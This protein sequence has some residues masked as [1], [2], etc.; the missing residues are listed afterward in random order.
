MGVAGHHRIAVGL[1][2]LDQGL[3]QVAQLFVQAIDRTA[4]PEPKVCRH[5]IIARARC[6]QASRRIAD[7]FA[8]TRLDI[9]VNVLESGGEAKTPFIEFSQNFV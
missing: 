3:L 4:H 7:E 8:K 1:G 5:L 6:V 9:H 2:Q